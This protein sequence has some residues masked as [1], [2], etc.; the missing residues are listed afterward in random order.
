MAGTLRLNLACL[1]FFLLASIRGNAQSFSGTGGAIPDN[2]QPVEFILEVGDLPQG[3]LDTV[4]YGLEEVCI[5][6]DHGWMSHL[7]I[8]LIAPDGTTTLLTSA[9]GNNGTSYANTCFTHHASTPVLHGAP[10]FNGHYKPIGQMGRVNNGQSGVGSWKLRILDTYPGV[11]DGEL[12]TWSITFSS[13]PSAYIPF[14]TSDLPILVIDTQGAL[15]PDEPKVTGTLFVVDNGPGMINHA[16]GPYNDYQGY[17]GIE[18][19]GHS[20]AMAPK[21]S[22]GIELRDVAGNDISAPVLG[23]PA[24]EDWVL[25]ANHYDKTFLNNT[26][27][28]TLAQEM[29][30]YA[31]RHR[32]VDVVMNGEHLGLFVFME[33]LKRD[34]Q[35]IAVA[36]LDSTDLT[37]DAVT[38][39]Y[40]IKVD[41]SNQLGWDSPHPP[42]ASPWGQTIHFNYHYPR[43]DRIMPEQAAYIQAYVDS[44]ETALAGADFAHP[45]LG[46]ANYIDVHSF[47]DLFIV[48]ELSR[49][50]DGYRLSTFMHKNR[51]S[52]GGKLRMGPVWDYD[53]AWGNVNYCE[54]G[55]VSG[56]AY[57]FSAVCPLD[58][59]QIPF[60]WNRLLEDP[61][62]TWTLR[63]RWEQLREDVLS[64]A[65]LH[66]YCDSMA[67]RLDGA[68]ERNFGIWPVLGMQTW[69]NP[70]PIPTTYQGEIDAL[71]QWI[72]ARTE[73][74]DEHM[75]GLANNC[76]T[77]VAGREGIKEPPPYPNPFED[78]LMLA[79]SEPA[80]VRLEL[81]DVLGRPVM[82]AQR[83]TVGP[84]PRRCDIRGPLPAG[85]YLLRVVAED[86]ET[87]TF[88]V[89]RR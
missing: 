89:H 8:W 11:D 20:S 53:I 1:F 51:N 56:W 86:G 79:W 34:G 52:L 67:V 40:I 83:M 62:F 78:H 63:C 37:G 80:V 27:T 9:M 46:Y 48:N 30:H 88:R 42:M 26:L 16:S 74:L 2:G 14:T 15:V 71:K 33:H 35:R 17:I 70:E 28:Y 7:D 68:Q 23:M 32:H 54:G 50:V 49:N 21:K 25:S 84:E 45:T 29:G 41:R 18:K 22:Y 81:L 55:L 36:K 19:R 75:P 43:A 13:D 66:A 65:R 76:T 61:L 24:G 58:A 59:K 47:I 60:W 12:L 31:A 57:E 85:T 77:A 82:P 44:F 69:S 3:T 38:G 5:T 72:S 87:R 73:W 4:G 64:T 10:P 39:G 6:I